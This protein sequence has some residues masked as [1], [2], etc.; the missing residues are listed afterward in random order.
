[1]DADDPGFRGTVLALVIVIIV[2]TIT[3]VIDYFVLQ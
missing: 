1:M 2:C 3:V